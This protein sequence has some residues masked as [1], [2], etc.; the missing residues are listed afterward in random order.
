MTPF[1]TQTPAPLCALLR[2]ATEADLP[3][4]VEI[5][6]STIPG[7]LATAHTTPVTIESRRPWFHEHNPRI[8]PPWIAEIPAAHD[9]PAALPASSASAAHTAP[10]E[11][12]IAAW[13][14][15][16]SFLNARPAYAATAEI[17][18][19]IAE[20][21][22]RAGLGAWLL[23]EALTRAP[24][25]GI[26]TLIANIFGH[27]APSLHLFH[28]HGFETWGRLPRVAVLDGIDRDLVILGKRLGGKG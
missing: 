23:S 24:A 7:R 1:P 22:R 11:P 28:N 14:S 17:S 19:Y 2:A 26:T 5:Y 20:K 3:A 25:C 4:I 8:R 16:N 9:A 18:I 13:L 12:V 15:L 21:Y 27:N 6:N 10:A